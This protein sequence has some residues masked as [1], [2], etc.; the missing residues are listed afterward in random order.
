MLLL[1][2]FLQPTLHYVWGYSHIYD[3]QTCLISRLIAGGF[4]SDGSGDGFLGEGGDEG[5]GFCLG[6]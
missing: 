6:T 3:L 5:L 4:L 1:H 2:Q